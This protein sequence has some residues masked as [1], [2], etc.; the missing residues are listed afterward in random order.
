[1]HA[2][3][4][5]NLMPYVMAPSPCNR[6]ILFCS[7]TS[8]RKLKIKEFSTLFIGSIQD[9]LA[10]A[11]PSTACINVLVQILS[12]Y[13]K[14][15]PPFVDHWMKNRRARNG[16]QETPPSFSYF[17]NLVAKVRLSAQIPLKRVENGGT[18]A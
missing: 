7:V 17:C 10:D 5:V 13:P 1:M 6:T 3:V 15:K 2:K 4:V 8:C 16:C 11:Y 18:L 14:C 12:L 9:G